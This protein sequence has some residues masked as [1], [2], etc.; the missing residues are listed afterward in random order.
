MKSRKKNARKRTARRMAA[1]TVASGTARRG[2]AGP[3]HV[4]RQRQHAERPSHGTAY[5]FA[6]LDNATDLTFNQ[7][8]GINDAGVIAGYFGSGAQGHPNKGYLLLPP[9]G[10]RQLRQRE[11]PRLGADPGHR[12]EQPRRHGRASG[13][14]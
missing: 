5:S 14:A 8:L 9:Y 6:T 3:H 13:P 7:L 10:Q 12:A 4:G 11:L 1:T 2:G